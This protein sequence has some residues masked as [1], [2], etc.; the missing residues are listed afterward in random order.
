MTM[1]LCAV[2]RRSENIYFASDSRL[3][4]GSTVVDL[5]I[6]IVRVPYRIFSPDE[7]G[8]RSILVEGDLGMCF[9]GSASGAL[10]LKETIGDV[11]TTMQAV[12][13]YHDISMMNVADFVFR[14]Y[15][16]I[17]K[18]LCAGIFENGLSTVVVAG[19]CSVEKRLRAFHLETNRQ[20]QHSYKEVLRNAQDQL[21]IGSGA[22]AAETKL[23]A[24]SSRPTSLD[25]LKVVQSV[26]DDSEVS[27]VG[28]HLQYGCFNGNNFQTY[29]IYEL[30]DAVH[31]WRGAV[32]LRSDDFDNSKSL[33]L[34][35]PFI[36]PFDP[37]DGV[38]CR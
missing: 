22:T 27:S 6:K 8:K 30:T 20:S 31:Y 11:L 5:A 10:F 18:T 29:G 26:I 23:T 25:I 4:F 38:R 21:F 14:A 17:S 3:T 34:N 24:A 16:S 37:I 15:R 9:A 33:V 2:W 32:D 1:T 7:N 19:F 13:G 35:Y 28:G 12:P 36:D